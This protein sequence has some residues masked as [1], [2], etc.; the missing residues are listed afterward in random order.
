MVF[1]EQNFL[2]K[3][4]NPSASTSKEA[5][6]DSNFIDGARFEVELDE[7][8]HVPQNANP[9]TQLD[10]TIEQIIEETLDQAE[11]ENDSDH[12]DEKQ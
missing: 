6:V 8:T 3:T 11:E 9:E 4:T 12:G 10:P 2:C 5:S 1:N 7:E